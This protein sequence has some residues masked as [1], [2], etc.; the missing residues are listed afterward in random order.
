MQQSLPNLFA[1][2]FRKQWF[3]KIVNFQK[4]SERYVRFG[5][6]KTQ[7]AISKSVPS[8]LLYGI[9]PVQ[10]ALLHRKRVLFSLSIKESPASKRLKYLQN[11]AHEISL[12]VHYLNQ[13]QLDILCPQVPHQGVVLSCGPLPY[14]D[15]DLL[16]TP[17]PAAKATHRFPIYVAM[18]RIEDPR[19]LG[20]IV[21]SCAFFNV[22]G[23]IVPRQ[24]SSPLSPAVSKSSAGMVESFP[25][26]AVANLPRFL[27]E[28]KK[29]GYWIV[30][31]DTQAELS[32]T[33]LRQDRPYI[34]VVGNEG[35]G[36]R[37]LVKSSC[38]WQV[39]ISGNIKVAAL[40]VSNATAIALYQ[41]TELRSANSE[42]FSR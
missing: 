6:K 26:M 34:L 22:S 2:G 36:M 4:K 28:Q 18:D 35:Q 41:L 19:N 5:S 15:Y 21:R 23:V 31:L 13:G 38:D 29:K 11:M 39:T 12:S 7:Q 17:L 32:V 40:N 20:A 1:H 33:T 9:L 27:K 37:K 3:L 42:S 24:N 8:E 25:V 30:G 16:D 14:A 10:Q